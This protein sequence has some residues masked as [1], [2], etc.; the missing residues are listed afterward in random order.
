MDNEK[1]EQLQRELDDIMLKDG[2]L[3]ETDKR[4]AQKLVERIV[5]G[6]L[7][8]FGIAIVLQVVKL[9][10]LPPPSL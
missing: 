4:Y 8:L 9:L 1:A 7:A 5:F 6:I 10:G 2:L 3:K